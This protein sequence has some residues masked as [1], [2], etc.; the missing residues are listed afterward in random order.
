MLAIPMSLPQ[1]ELDLL[2]RLAKIFRWR[3]VSKPDG[4]RPSCF[5]LITNL[6]REKDIPLRLE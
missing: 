5:F 4:E 1:A 6:C 3:L 2:G